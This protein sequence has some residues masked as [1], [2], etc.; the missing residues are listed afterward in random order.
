MDVRHVR[1][2][3][4]G[5]S[6]AAKF[7][8]NSCVSDPANE[9]L[10]Q[11]CQSL[12]SAYCTSESVSR[13]SSDDWVSFIETAICAAFPNAEYNSVV[14]EVFRKVLALND[15][16]EIRRVA[17]ASNSASA[18]NLCLA[19]SP[20]TKLFSDASRSDHEQLLHIAVD[21]FATAHSS[22]M[23]T[24]ERLDSIRQPMPTFAVPFENTD[25]NPKQDVQVDA[26]CR[27][28]T[29]PESRMPASEERAASV[30]ERSFFSCC[31]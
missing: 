7:V 5:L 9:Q 23:A 31:C 12:A 24:F 2:S 8:A 26:S 14:L 15:L 1:A 28:N 27:E 29:D 25:S 19:L 18:P 4:A 3:F 20:F 21:E 30:K 13:N 17:R 6:M 22:T 11:S 16:G 10:V